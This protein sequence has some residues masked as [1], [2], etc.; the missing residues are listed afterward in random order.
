MP[1]GP[2][3]AGKGTERREMVW[4]WESKVRDETDGAL[5]M[6]GIVGMPGCGGSRRRTRARRWDSLGAF[7]A[8]CDRGRRGGL[9]SSRAASCR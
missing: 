2:E 3:R 5:T 4:G 1:A 7:L 9:Y 6:V 8:S